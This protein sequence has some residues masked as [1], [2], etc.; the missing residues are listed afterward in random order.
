[1]DLSWFGVAWLC[2]ACLCLAAGMWLTQRRNTHGTPLPTAPPTCQHCGATREAG[3]HFCG[4]CGQRLRR[5]TS[6]MLVS[7]EE[8]R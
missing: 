5:A 8:R 7:R 4:A 1:M 2:A 6:R 3:A